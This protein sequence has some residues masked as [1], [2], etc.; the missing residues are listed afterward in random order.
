[1]E[2]VILGAI[3]TGGVVSTVSVVQQGR[4]T[5][6]AGEMQEAIALRR[7]RIAEKQAIAEQEAAGEAAKVQAKEAEALRGR[8]IALY[9]KG[10]VEMRGTPL[11]V[12][13]Q[14]AEEM[15]ADRLRILTEGAISG[16]QRRAEAQIIRMQ[17]AAAKVR[18]KA[19]YRGSR[20]A[21]A[22][23]ILSTVGAAGYMG[24]RMQKPTVSPGFRRTA[25]RA[26]KWLSTPPPL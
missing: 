9:A 7:A 12:V 10:G 26:Q 6:A 18:G 2:A 21:A 4:A 16:A 3:I 15:E 11:S 23:T 8:Q 20:L 1:M 22:G 25:V 17:G 14:T 13:I 19:A 5:R 24:Y